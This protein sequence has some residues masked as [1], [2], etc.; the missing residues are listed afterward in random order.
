M[1]RCSSAEGRRQ[2]LALL[3]LLRCCVFYV[4]GCG[5]HWGSMGTRIGLNGL[6]SALSKDCYVRCTQIEYICPSSFKNNPT[7]TVRVFSTTK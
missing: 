7:K 3:L 5:G 4:G 1:G 6:G 2:L